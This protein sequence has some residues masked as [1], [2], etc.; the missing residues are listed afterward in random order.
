MALEASGLEIKTLG[1]IEAEMDEAARAAISPTLNLSSTSALGQLKSITASHASELWDALEAVWLSWSLPSAT[2][3]ELDRL[4][5]LTGVSRRAAYPSRVY[6][7]LDIEAGTYAAG[8]IV[9]NLVGDP[10]VRFT[11]SEEITLGAD[12]PAF[13]NV[14]FES[15]TTGPVQAGAGF[16]TVITTP[17]AGLNAATNPADAIEGAN[18]ESDSALR[19]R[20][21]LSRA[22]GGTSSVD[23]IRAGLL[24][25]E[26]VTFAR[27]TENDLLTTVGGIPG[28]AFEATVLGG[29]DTQ[30]AA[31]IFARKPAGIQAYGNT[32]ESVV[33]SQGSAHL[34]GFT[35][36]A[37]VN[38][39]LA[40]TLSYVGGTF[41]GE[42]VVK[43]TLSTWGDA[44]LG[45][46]NDVI[47]ARLLQI[48]MGI[49]G[50]VDATVAIGT[51]P[52]PVTQGN[53]VITPQQ[54][55][56]LD[57]TRITVAAGSI[58]GVP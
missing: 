32:V 36:P 43:E 24:G 21:A 3:A 18:V 26:G 6:M 28:K 4:A 1:E 35:R 57:P 9:V 53:L 30:I 20:I 52:N 40:V 56:R 7:T 42:S 17:V 58:G 54:I 44:N 23:A 50:T 16:L 2:G 48:I 29:D 5:A 13:A 49:S 25:L 45:P 39:Y 47:H 41:P 55:A 12:D 10:S 46:G 33:D 11:N 37:D 51:A 27:V 15:E 34:I 14:P 19:A 38:V 8:T 31:E 22:S